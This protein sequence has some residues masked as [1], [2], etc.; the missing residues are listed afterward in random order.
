MA[1]DHIHCG[2]SNPP[3]YI[4]D[5]LEGPMR[6]PGKKEGVMIITLHRKGHLE[7]THLLQLNE[8]RLGRL[9]PLARR[10]AIN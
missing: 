10:W 5:Q 2:L 6:V 3:I 4:K 7:G 8:P 1:G 9:N